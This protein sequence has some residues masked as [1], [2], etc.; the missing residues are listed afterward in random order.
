[1]INFLKQVKGILLKKESAPITYASSNEGAIYNN[2]NTDMRTQIAGAD[3]AVVTDTQT[4]T[5]TNKTLTSPV[6][7]APTGITKSDVGL[8]NVDNTSDA[9]KNAATATLT[10]KT[11][12]AGSNTITGLADA[13]IASGANI[14]AAKIGTGAVSTTEFDYLDGVTSAIQT[15]LNGKEPTITTLSVAKGGTNSGTALNNN[16]VIQSSGGAIVE[17]AAITASRALVSDS[18]GIPTHSAV[19][20]TELGYVS[21]V[22][23]SI[24]TQLGNK[25]NTLVNSAGLAAALSDETG[26]GLAVF[27][28]SPS[29]ITPTIDIDVRT[30]QGST[31]A[32]PSSGSTKVYTK[33]DNKLYVLDS[34]GTETVVGA[35]DVSLSTMFQLIGT[36]PANTWASGDNAAFLGGGT[37]AGT[38]V[39]NTTAPLH[40]V[41]DYVYT[42]AAGSLNDYIAC[43][44]Q[45]VDVRFRGN[46]AYFVFDYKYDGANSDILPI[47]YDVTNSTIISDQTIYLPAALN[48][49]QTFSVA[50]A[51]P[52]SCASIRI[53]YHVKAVNSGKIFQFDDIQ[54]TDD[55]NT[56]IQV[57]NNTNWIPYTPTFTGFGT[58]TNI[59]FFYKRSG[60]NVLIRGYFTE[61]SST[62]VEARVSLPSGLTSSSAM[63]PLEMCGNYV[64]NTGFG[65]INSGVGCEPSSTYVTFFI[66]DSGTN[67]MTKATGTQLGSS[68]NFTL[69]ASVPVQGW[70]ETSPSL[71][72]LNA[73][74]DWTSYTPSFTGFGTASGITA[75]HKRQGSDLLLRVSWT[76]GTTTATEARVSFPSGLVGSSAMASIEACGHYTIDN[77]NN[78]DTLS[79]EPGVGYF[80]FQQRNGATFN[81]VKLDGNIFSSTSKM[82]A[83][84]RI[85]IQGWVNSN[86]IIGTFENSFGNWTTPTTITIGATTTPPTK[87]TIVKDAVKIRSMGKD[88]FEAEYRYSHTSGGGNGSGD[89]LLSL[90]TGYAFDLSETPV[91]TGSSNSDVGTILAE[92][93]TDGRILNSSLNYPPISAHVY[94]S[95]Q[96]RLS[97][98]GASTTYFGSGFFNFAQN[99]LGFYVKIKFKGTGP[100]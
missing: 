46:V 95:T 86:V 43:P 18:N 53:G 97:N 41:A 87:G 85:P 83:Y 80:T 6:I 69:N 35:G 7:S 31:P 92:V 21:G 70:V 1:M 32:T 75:Y 82:S 74:Y 61:G 98:N 84:A 25:Q 77:T 24:Q 52:S 96:F 57:Q 63:A 50:V 10:N 79:C 99:P 12:A 91:Y 8:G 38:F 4:Q 100:A 49:A 48:S 64:N 93:E 59:N 65:Y 3:R 20:D 2:N 73:D 72:V 68:L 45:A 42:Q 16:R 33:T 19:T 55:Y 39:R 11:I 58:A 78:S 44:V 5:L 29:L 9:T 81:L 27:N 62:G 90:P 13:N 15:Q 14:D 54:I 71:S 60:T 23:S 76:A 34:T 40:G 51:I 88:W 56:V 22:T 30:N 89:Y 28:N 94:S 26:S 47:V 17:A 36:E 66:K 67:G 37:L